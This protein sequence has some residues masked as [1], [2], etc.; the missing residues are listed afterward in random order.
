MAWKQAKKAFKLNNPKKYMGDPSK[1]LYKSGWE[2]TAFIMCDNNPN[3]IRWGYEIIPIKY[4]KPIG[5]SFKTTYYLP[6][7]YVEYFD[8]DKNFIKEVIEIKPKN[9]TVPSKRRKAGVRLAENYAYVVNRAKWDA[10]EAWCT[11]RGIKFSIL[12][13]NG[14]FGNKKAK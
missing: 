12:T 10:A 3:I 6:D 7:L 9:Q 1:L 2:E 14:L 8:R 11:S 13:E 5:S 4:N